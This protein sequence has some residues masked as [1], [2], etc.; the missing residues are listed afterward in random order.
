[1]R[2]QEF[3]KTIRRIV[4]PVVEGWGFSSEG[5][6]GCTFRRKISDELFHFIAFDLKAQGSVFEVQ[7]F[8]ATP[9]LGT[10]QWASF[11]DFVGIPT[12]RTA[13]L[14]AKLGVGAGASRFPCKDARSLEFVLARVVLPA[15]TAYAPLYLENFHTVEDII[16]FLEYPQW[17]A[18]LR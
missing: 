3:D 11:P 13:G 18:L 4:G 6:C 12:G 14:N 10:E 7:V 1:M 15:L 17:A 16:P 2:D 9:K 5:G 8:P